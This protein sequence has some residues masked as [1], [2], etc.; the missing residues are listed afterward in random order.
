M[1][2]PCIWCGYYGYSRKGKPLCGACDRTLT[3][4][5]IKRGEIVKILCGMEWDALYSWSVA[6]FPFGEK[7]HDRGIPYLTGFAD[8]ILDQIRPNKKGANP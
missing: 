6:G 4:R 3:S 7:F 1:S 8:K 5:D 2:E